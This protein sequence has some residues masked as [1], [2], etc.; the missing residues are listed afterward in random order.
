MPKMKAPPAPVAQNPGQGTMSKEL[1]I[2]VIDDDE[3]FRV[4][5]VESLC[6]QGYDA[7]GF[8]SA[9]E[10][11]ARDA[12]VWWGCVITDIHMP[13]MSGIDLK[14]FLAASGSRVP[15]IMITAR[16]EPELEA[17]AVASGAFCLLRKPFDSKALID[18]LEK[19]LIASSAS[20]PRDL[21]SV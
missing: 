11:V 19:A 2:A 6:S 12:E 7:R 1:S 20:P 9:D 4:A 8:A 15:V 17:R 14:R 3:P 18:C 10:F 5:L 13:G 16:A 21:P